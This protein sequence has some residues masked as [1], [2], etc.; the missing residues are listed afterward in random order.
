MPSLIGHS[1][2]ACSVYSPFRRRF[3]KTPASNTIPAFKTVV[4]Q[5]RVLPPDGVNESIDNTRLS[6]YTEE[7]TRGI[8]NDDCKNCHLDPKT[9]I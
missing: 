5:G 4:P 8:T 6:G 1:F 7:N 2:T 3:P 9:S